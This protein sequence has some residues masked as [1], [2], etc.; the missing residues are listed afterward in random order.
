[1]ARDTIVR[2]THQLEQILGLYAAGNH[3]QVQSAVEQLLDSGLSTRELPPR[4]LAAYG[5]SMAAENRERAAEALTLARAAQ[6]SAPWDPEITLACARVLVQTGAKDQALVVLG[7]GLRSDPGHEGM[8]RLRAS[9][10]YRMSPVLPL[11][12]RASLINRLLGRI[13]YWL[14]TR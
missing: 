2:T 7:K 11:L 8:L 4:V 6:K 13:R 3:R 9:L 12:P 10:G 14:V 5:A 1:M